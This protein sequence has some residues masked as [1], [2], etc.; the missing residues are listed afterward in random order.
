MS[1]VP[2]SILAVLFADIYS[3]VRLYELKGDAEA[4]RL[5]AWSIKTM[6]EITRLFGGRLVGTRGGRRDEY[7]RDGQR[8]LWGGPRDAASASWH[9]DSDQGGHRHRPGDRR[10]WRSFR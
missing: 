6:C 8:R 2:S 7:V 4:Q 3:S 5:T 9:P 10:E 1:P